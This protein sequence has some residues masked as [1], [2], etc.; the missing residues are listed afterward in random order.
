MDSSVTANDG[1]INQ[2]SNKPPD[3]L[4]VFRKSLAM[5]RGVLFGLS[6][7]VLTAPLAANA[8]WIQ[9]S[10]TPSGKIYYD[11]SKTQRFGTKIETMSLTNL[12]VVDLGARSVVNDI[13]Y[14]CESREMRILT[15]TRYSEP[16]GKGVDLYFADINHGEWPETFRA[17]AT[18][19]LFLAACKDYK[20]RFDNK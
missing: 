14:D 7:L 18:S 20:K 17:S 12:P 3:G 10:E 13:E 6:L 2:S 4:T 5:K 9:V 16:Y 11:P 19:P 8:K 15:L 1:R